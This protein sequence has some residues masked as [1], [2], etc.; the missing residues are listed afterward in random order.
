[1]RLHK[2]ELLMRTTLA[3]HLCE[4]RKVELSTQWPGCSSQCTLSLRGIRWEKGTSSLSAISWLR[5]CSFW[6]CFVPPLSLLFELL[7]SQAF[8][9]FSPR[10]ISSLSQEY[11]L[12]KRDRSCL[13]CFVS[14]TP[15]SANLRIPEWGNNKFKR[16]LWEGAGFRGDESMLILAEQSLVPFAKTALHLGPGKNT[17]Q[18]S[19][20]ALRGGAEE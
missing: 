19:I 9:D 3:K 20:P 13:A 2:Y 1:M 12:P 14:T 6:N 5:L 7:Y 18:R 10:R 16:V 17:V 11:I 8:L 4:S 15:G